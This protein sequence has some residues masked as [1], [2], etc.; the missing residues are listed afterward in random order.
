MPGHA[1]HRYGAVLCQERTCRCFR[2]G[3]SRWW[4]S[5]TAAMCMTCKRTRQTGLVNTSQRAQHDLENQGKYTCIGVAVQAHC[6]R[7]ARVAC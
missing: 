3:S 6:M 4:I 1:D 2:P 5:C 7:L